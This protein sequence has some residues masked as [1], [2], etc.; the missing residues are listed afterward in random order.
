VLLIVAFDVARYLQRATGWTVPMFLAALAPLGLVL[1][2]APNLTFGLF[3]ALGVAIGGLELADY[4]RE[5]PVV[6]AEGFSA[7]RS[8]RLGALVAM[9]LGATAFLVGVTGSPL[10]RPESVF[11]WHAVWHVLAALAMGLYAY[12]AIEPH[13]ARTATAGP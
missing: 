10:C 12:G 5:V 1:A 7:R 9:A 11:Q 8:A 2:L 13:P 6:R 3:V 4:R